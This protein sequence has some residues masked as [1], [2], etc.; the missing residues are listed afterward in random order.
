MEGMKNADTEIVSENEE[1]TAVDTAV[2]DEN[3]K[4]G[5]K[6]KEKK[7]KKEKKPRVKWKDLPK[8]TRKK[9]R[10]RYILIGVA[11]IILVLII[12]AK[13]SAANAKMPVF[14]AP[15][16]VGDVEATITTS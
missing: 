2:T 13:I 3:V 6:K 8:E 4:K 11:V 12:S 15:V 9:K 1:Y 16:T 5:K 7:E 14:T 10:R